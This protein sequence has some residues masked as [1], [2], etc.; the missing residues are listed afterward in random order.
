[1]KS[2]HVS[3]ALRALS[4][5]VLGCGSFCESE[6]ITTNVLEVLPDES[7][8]AVDQESGATLTYLTT[9]PASDTNL[10]FHERSWTSDGSVILF[11]SGRETGGLMGYLVET[12][13][14]I[15]IGSFLEGS[16]GGATAA[17]TGNR[18]FALHD[19][20]AVEI[21][22][23]VDVAAGTPT[24]VT[25][26]YRRIAPLPGGSGTTSL[27]ESCDGKYLAI[28][29]MD[30]ADGGD[31]VILL[32]AVD[33][34]EVRELCRVGAPQ[35]FGYHVQWSHT[36]P[37]LLSFAGSRPRL[38][39]VDIR[40]GSIT[41]PYAELEGELVTHE[42][43]WV[44]DQIVFCGGMH[45]KPTED[46][47]VKVVDVHTGQ[48]RIIGAGSWWP[49]ATP[50]EVSKYNYWHCAGSDDGRWVVA[51]NWHG[52]IT[53]FEA[54]TTRP[55]VLTTGHRSYGKGEHPHVG[56][57]RASKQVIFTSH[58]NGN[59]DVCIATIPDAWQAANPAP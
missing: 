48:V 50:Q 10:Y 58:T 39:V 55:H 36:N 42:H 45:P 28:G 44:N 52:G 6:L 24:K 37:N 14:L 25:A 17:L 15:R 57:D 31:S 38:N 13:E 27:N 21:S 4:I 47:H 2:H 33:T 56:W 34:G 1:M 51:D 23:N 41:N 49:D 59:P 46:A 22:L 18:L 5:L 54:K 8:T 19:N 12:G 43:W 32:I 3:H 40:D 35:T 53:L 20:A 11:Y 9:N 30:P 29:I 16:L 26:S 7:L